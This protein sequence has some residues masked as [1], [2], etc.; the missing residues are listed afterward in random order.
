MEQS[1]LIP[2]TAASVLALAISEI[3]PGS[4]LLGG[5][6]TR[7]GFFYQFFA[8]Y[9][10]PP[11]AI[12]MLE[13]RMRQ[14]IREERE[15]R[16][17]EMVA[18]SAREFFESQGHVAAVNALEEMEAKELVSVLTI[19]GVANLME[20]PFCSTVKEIGAFKITSLKS[21]GDLEYRVEGSAFATK[22]QLKHF[23][24]LLVRYET[25][26]HLQVGTVNGYWRSENGH[27]VWLKQGLEA[28]AAMIT[29]LKNSFGGD[30]CRA[31]T[32][33]ILDQYGSIKARKGK[34]FT[35]WTVL[36]KAVD[37]EGDEGFFEDSVQTIAGH[38]IYCEAREIAPLITSLLQKTSKT[39]IILGFDPQ[40]RLAGRK[41]NEKGV[42]ILRDLLQ[43]YLPI[44][45]EADSTK[46]VST[47]R[48]MVKDGL[49]RMHSA[50]ELEIGLEMSIKDDG[51]A[52]IRLKAGVE[53]ILSLLLEEKGGNLPQI[54]QKG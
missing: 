24:H 3:F 47:L 45:F 21:L 10:L 25:G 54:C 42:K 27:F 9:Q 38:F 46:G 26:N 7:T 4:E 23:L 34:P 41:Q 32:L 20:G 5:G 53:R 35:A 14:I 31:A 43:T 12:P 30:E 37:P 48:W 36:E 39:L 8:S 52:V 17:M 28:R 16:E 15:I 51:L 49:G 19:G 13:E 2:R 6:E 1:K 11:E 50:L 33:S 18:C 22:D 44:P 29:F 40:L